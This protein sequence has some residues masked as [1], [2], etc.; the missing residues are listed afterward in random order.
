[1]MNLSDYDYDLPEELIAG[2][3][4]ADRPSARLLKADKITGRLSH[5]EFRDV[6]DF[7]IPGDVLV[8]NNTKV[9]PARLFGKKPTG[10]QVEALLLKKIAAHEWKALLRPGG[11]I[12]KGTWV[13]FGDDSVHL[14]G[15]VLDDPIPDSGE[16]RLLFLGD[17]IEEKLK[18]IGHIPL[19]P[20]LDRPDTELDREM[21]QTVFAEKEGAVAS[22][23]AGLHFNDELLSSLENKGIEIVKVTLHVSYGTFQ[24]LVEENLKKQQLFP[25]EFEVSEK[26]AL[27]VNRA[28]EEKR[29]VIAC[30]TTTVRTLESA[31]Q[32]DGRLKA[33]S[34]ETRLFI[35]PPFDFKVVQGMITNFHL[36]KSSLLMLVAALM[37]KEKLRAAYDEA[38]REQY[39]FYSYGDAMIYI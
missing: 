29:R 2:F 21:Y 16:R 4:P 17:R 32:A 18:K 6:G 36:P 7:L 20:Y 39:R 3:P 28:L 31:V 27:T 5:H 1:M 10:G 11:R 9:I 25:E 35:H 24:P 30:G 22:P 26:A 8:L 23:T 34:G 19:P 37:G 12:R 38:V 13:E 14:T 33:C 15:E